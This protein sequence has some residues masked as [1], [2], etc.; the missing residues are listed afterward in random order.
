MLFVFKIL[1]INYV[2]LYFASFN[3]YCDASDK[4]VSTDERNREEHFEKVYFS[5][6]NYTNNWR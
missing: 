6:Q 1:S 3:Q 5:D 2:T 4:V